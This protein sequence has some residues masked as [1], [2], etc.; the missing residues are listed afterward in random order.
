MMI[1]ER[2]L[3]A[4][5]ANDKVQVPIRIFK[6]EQTNKGG[7]SCRYE[8]DWPDGR[9]TM[10]AEGLDAVQSL[11]NALFMIGSE[12]YTSNFHKSGALYLDEPGQGYGFPVPVTL[13]H[14][15]TGTDARFF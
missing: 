7:W 15:L 12:I 8:I 5:I 1:A 11:L 3:R 9:W 6:P 2:I 4:R 13:R 14:L 10:V